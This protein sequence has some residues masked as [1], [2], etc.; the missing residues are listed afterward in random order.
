LETAEEFR[1]KDMAKYSIQVEATFA[2]EHNENGV[3]K[4]G[5]IK[6]EIFN[7]ETLKELMKGVEENIGNRY[8]FILDKSLD[9][10]IHYMKRPSGS[11]PPWPSSFQ[12]KIESSRVFCLQGAAHAR[13]CARPHRISWPL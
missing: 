10:Y 13:C 7:D 3:M 8:R 12:K 11:G 6:T 4:T 5:F 9:V 2:E 1:P